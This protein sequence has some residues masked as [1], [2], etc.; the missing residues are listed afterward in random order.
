MRNDEISLLILF[1]KESLR[2]EDYKIIKC[3]EAFMMQKEM[4][5]NFEELIS[6]RD[7][8]RIELEDLEQRKKALDLSGKEYE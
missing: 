6:K 8:I 5:Y 2:K 1:K 4:P 7:A 3:F